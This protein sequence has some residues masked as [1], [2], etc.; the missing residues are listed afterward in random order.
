M[1]VLIC[2]Y[3]IERVIRNSVNLVDAMGILTF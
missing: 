1:Y 2:W 3:I